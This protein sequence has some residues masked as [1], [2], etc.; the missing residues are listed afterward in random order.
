MA[1]VHDAPATTKKVMVFMIE[2][3]EIGVMILTPKRYKDDRGF[4]SELWRDEHAVAM[5]ISHGFVQENH[6][7]STKVGTLRGLH[8]QT[9]PA[10]QAKLVR[11][12]RGALF[13]VAVDVRSGSPT[14]GKWFGIELNDKNGKQLYIPSG[15]LHGFQTLMPNTEIVY[16]CSNYYSTSHE[17][18]VT[19]KDRTL[20]IEWP[21]G[22]DDSLMSQ[23]DRE[24][25]L[26]ASLGELASFG[27]N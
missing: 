1:R 2:R 25:A 18:T 6:S 4:F 15:F 16:K 7:M 20:G 22:I 5:G 13:D 11:C 21:L 12:G 3:E 17:I 9:A 27:K 23:K 8:L 26:L 19:P 14:F 24:G 10:A